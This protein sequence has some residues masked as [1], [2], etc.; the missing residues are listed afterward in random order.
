MDLSKLE[1]PGAPGEESS[2]LDLGMEEGLGKSDSPLTDISDEDL[3]AEVKARGIEDMLADSEG[4]DM[5]GDMGDMP[6]PDEEV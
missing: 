6:M 2:E 1:M 3:I 4:D 5:P